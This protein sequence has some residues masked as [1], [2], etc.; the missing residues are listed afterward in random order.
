M[1]VVLAGSTGFLGQEILSQCL[2]NPSITSVI[3]LSRRDIPISHA[4]LTVQRMTESEFAS[5]SS[6]ELKSSLRGAD[7]CIWSLGVTP[8]MANSDWEKLRQ[9][10]L[11]YTRAAV[12]AFS[13]LRKEKDSQSNEAKKFRFVY[14]SGS[15][16]ERDQNRSL[17]VKGYYRKVRVCTSL[18]LL[19][20][21]FILLMFTYRYICR[22]KQ[23]I[24]FSTIRKRTTALSSRTSCGRGGLC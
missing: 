11:D 12:S 8:S 20:C 10:S 3:A 5:F 6:P 21:F 1:K 7:A 17:W 2:S 4:K 9:V 13:D 22:A 16:T 23:R 19:S 15:L 24:S 14:F 18:F